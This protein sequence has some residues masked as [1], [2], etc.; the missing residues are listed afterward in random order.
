M[1]DLQKY[2]EASLREAGDSALRIDNV[3][4]LQAYIKKNSIQTLEKLWRYLVHA[5][6]GKDLR[7]ANI[8]SICNW[9]F[10][11]AFS[12]ML[13]DLAQNKLLIHL[14]LQTPCRGNTRLS[15]YLSPAGLKALDAAE[16]VMGGYLSLDKL[17]GHYTLVTAENTR[18][19][20]DPTDLGTISDAASAVYWVISII[21]EQLHTEATPEKIWAGSM[22]AL[23]DARSAA[24]FS[25]TGKDA[26]P[27]EERDV[28]LKA[29][30]EAWKQH[31]ARIDRE[32][33][34]LVRNYVRN[35][36]QIKE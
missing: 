13:E 31:R 8:S 5:R 25:H 19:N 14:V 12:G 16:Q 36:F 27:F 1:N 26:W 17:E 32:H 15:K 23:R 7:Y 33:I 34:R 11:L 20:P 10:D 35:P 18:I 9:L 4:R 6:C 29:W 24:I 30:Q 21:R 28:A 3:S 22:L 2:I